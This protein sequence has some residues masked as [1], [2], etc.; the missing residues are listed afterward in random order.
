M[1]NPT[2]AAGAYAAMQRLATPNGGSG[3]LPGLSGPNAGGPS[4]AQALSQVLDSVAQS[5]RQADAQAVAA[6]QGKA[7]MVDVVTA[8]AESEA[9]LQTLVAV[10]DKVIAAYEDI[11]RMPI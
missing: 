5:G 1:P 6:T 9:A 7:D 3:G 8:V 4:F 2:S 10:R 11:M